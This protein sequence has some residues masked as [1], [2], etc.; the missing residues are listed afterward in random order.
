MV[1][2]VIQKIYCGQ[3]N[4]PDL[5]YRRVIVTKE[6][7]QILLTKVGQGCRSPSPGTFLLVHKDEVLIISCSAWQSRRP[8]LLLPTLK[9]KLTATLRKTATPLRVILLVIPACSGNCDPAQ[10]L[11]WSNQ[12][13]DRVEQRV[14][15]LKRVELSLMLDFHSAICLMILSP[16][17]GCHGCSSYTSLNTPYVYTHSESRTIKSS[18]FAAW[19]RSEHSFVCFTYCHKFCLYNFGLSSPFSFPIP[20]LQHPSNTPWT[21]PNTPQTSPPIIP[22]TSPSYIPRPKHFPQ[23]IW[24]KK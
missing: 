1:D 12:H 6:T 24:N 21:H 11:F 16:M 10:F 17:V 2:V 3:G 4:I 9:H 14:E 23:S 8:L 13:P 19:S 5:V 15:F 22:P 20:H 7:W 18:L